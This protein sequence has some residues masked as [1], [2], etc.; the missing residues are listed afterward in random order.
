MHNL[1]KFLLCG[2][3]VAVVAG[4]GSASA[5]TSAA[6]AATPTPSGR[7]N[8]G[9]AAGQLVQVNGTKLTLSTTAGDVSVVYTSATTIVS[10]STGSTGD[11][12][13]GT[14]VVIV[15]TK[16][17]T[18]AVTATS[19][20]LSQGVNGAC[21]RTGG[22]GGGLFPGGAIPSFGA[23]ASARP[24]GAPTLN[25]NTTFVSGLVTAVTGELFT[26]RASTGATS[27][28][29]VPTTLSVTESSPGTATDLTVDTCVRAVGPKDSSGVVQARS[30]TLQPTDATGACTFGR[31]GGRFGGGGF[32]GGG[33]AAPTAAA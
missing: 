10:T 16:D 25:P 2:S 29:T 30:L 33:A 18:G 31:A 6:G 27:T 13:A 21:T 14:C 19:V 4:C 17:S 28:V 24:S 8:A 26:V 9:G 5:S 7:G 1:S 12:V 3:V 23:G 20:R 32:V 11:I 22:A 15:G